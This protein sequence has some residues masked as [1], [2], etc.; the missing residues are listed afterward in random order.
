MS[1]STAL[2]P[3]VYIAGPL[4]GP[5]AWENVRAAAL[6]AQVLVSMGCAPIVPHLSAFVDMIAP[7]PRE[8]WMSVDFAILAR[9]DA[10]LWLGSSPGADAECD[11]AMRLGLPI[12][13]SL[14][15][16]EDWLRSRS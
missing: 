2:M 3:V 11:E 13:P 15:A 8:T 6:A 9:C 10:V 5:N 1:R 4:S 16:A 7:L 12:L 14:A